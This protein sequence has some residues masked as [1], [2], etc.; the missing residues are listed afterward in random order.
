MC[1]AAVRPIQIF[2]KEIDKH[3]IPIVGG[4]GANLGE[5]T[6]AGFPVPNG[7]AITVEGYDRFIEENEL[8][9]YLYDV[10]ADTDVKN[11]ESLENASR[12]IQKKIVSCRMPE[13]VAHE[14][15]KGYKKLSGRFKRA[16]VAV[17]SSATAEDLPGASFA[18]Q[19][20]TYLNVR[21]DANLL[22]NVKACWASLFTARAIFYREENKIKHERVKISVIVQEM[23]PAEVSGVMFSID[24]VTNDRDRII[25]E[26]VRGLGEMIVQGSVVPDT[27]V[28]Q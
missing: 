26:A 20:A 16:L 18:G 15:I 2:F 9:K 24:P 23:V 1:M 27:Y 10:L 17:R 6:Q 3:D 28:V 11:P 12:K 25:V 22:E 21:G 8:Q 19:Q 7:F 4:K 13:L 14:T 5:M